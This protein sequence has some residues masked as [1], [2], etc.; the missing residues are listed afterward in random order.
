HEVRGGWQPTCTDCHDV[1]D[2]SSANL[3]L[4]ARMINTTG[5]VFQDNDL[6]SN[7]VSDFIHSNHASTS[8]DGVCEVCHTGTS[9]HRN[10]PAG[11][12]AHYADSLCTDCHPHSEG[13]KPGAGACTACH[14]QPPD[15]DVSPNLAGAHATHMTSTNGP[16]I[17]D[18]FECH[19]PLAAG[20]HLDGFTSFA[21]GVDA[22][23]NGD[24]ELSETDV[25]DACHSPGGAFDGVND[26]T[27]GAKP[28]WAEGVYSGSTLTPSK[29]LWCAGCHDDSPATI[30]GVDAPPVAGDN[31]TWGY[32]ATGHGRSGA[33]PCASCHDTSAPHFD[34]VANTYQAAADNYQEAFRLQSVNGGEPLVVP[35]TGNDWDDAY[36]DPSYWELCFT[37]HDRY[38]L[39]GGP[40]APAGPYY[41]D[42]F[43]TNFRSDASVLIPDGPPDTDIAQY[44][45]SGAADVNSH[46]THTVGPPHFYDSDRDGSVDSYGTCVACHNIHGSTSAAMVRDGKLLGMEPS[47]NFSRV[48]YD[49]HNP[50][51]GGC[52]DPIIMTSTNSVPLQE[53]HG[54]IMRTNS[55][56]GNNGVCNF[57]HGGGGSTGDPEYVINCYD[58]DN[59]DYYR[60]PVEA[61]NPC[62]ACHG[63]P[64]DG[65]EFPNTAGA[66]ATH[67]IGTN[68]PH[69]SD[70]FVC[71]A[72]LSDGVHNNAVASFASGID[73]NSN[74]DIE[75]DETDV[76]DACHSPDGPIDGVAE[77]IANW[78]AGT[79]VACAGC[80][81]TGTSTIQGVTAP[82]VAGDNVTW[83]Y[84]ATG[85]GRGG[86]VACTACHNA[87]ALHFDGEARTFSFES[88]QYGPSQSGVDYAAGYRLKDVDGEVP[89]M[90]PANYNITFDYNAAT[91]R[92]N[93]FR[94]CFSCHDITKVFDDTPGDGIDSNF[95]AS[96][97]NPPR[98]YSYA[99][100]S[101]A[102]VNEHVA[103]V[104]NYVG[105]FADSDWDEATDGP[106]GTEGRDSLTA[107]SSCHNVHGAAGNCGST[108]ETMI[109]DGSLV[110]RPGGYGFSH[111]VEDVGAGGY[112]TVT[113]VEAT[114]SN[115]VGAIFR[116]NT[117]NMCGGSMCHGNPDP[118]DDCSYDASGSSWGT[119]LEYF[120]PWEDHS[121]CTAC[122]ADAVDNGDNVPP[123]GRRA[124]V[125]EFPTGDAHAHYGAQFGDD[126]CGICHSLGTHTDG[127]VELID[128]DDASVYRF[129]TPA[130]LTADPDVSDFCS[131][132]HD[133]DGAQR[134][135]S[136]LD[137][138]GN[139]NAPPDA[140]SKFQG[141]LQWI[142]EY[143]DT[144]FGTWGTLRAVNSH[145]DISDS[146]QAFSGAKIE[147][148]DC[149]GAH[150]SA[151]SQPLIDPYAPLTPWAGDDDTFCLQCHNGGTGPQSPDLPAGVVGP[152][153]DTEELRS[154][155]RSIS[156]VCTNG[157]G[158]C[159]ALRGIESCEYTGAPW[160]VAYDWTHS[161]HGLTSKRGWTGYSG[162]P[163]A[164]VSCTVCHDPHGSYTPTNT[165]G[166]PYLI[167]D[168]VDGT[169]FVDDGTRVGGFNGP[170]FNSNGT[171][172]EVIVPADGVDVGWGESQG[173]CV[174]CHADWMAGMWAHDMCTACQGCHAHGSSW[175]EY[176]WADD[177]DHEPCPATKKAHGA[178]PAD[179][180][181]Q[182]LLPLDPSELTE[183]DIAALR[184]AIRTGMRQVQDGG[185]A[186]D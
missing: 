117:N 109:R 90:I 62:T 116:Y 75:L 65:T 183:E 79:P 85:H 14:G 42:E 9:Y 144:C 184:N 169:A 95:K 7:G 173:L 61:P 135:A 175:G 30:Q 80:H 18:C 180:T 164:T 171:V 132:C 105:P 166:N 89:L 21:S 123:G 66:H 68:G 104:M 129:Q 37:C 168:Q 122:H 125:P 82:P 58:P 141:T 77:G 63:Q 20:V 59:V 133:A 83:G 151:A 38:A 92:D 115:S 160:H 40:T 130:D 78:A 12:H 131:G 46:Y 6:G 27:I 8:Y 101:G 112:P 176:D 16:Q 22:N 156:D 97:P 24:I 179:G 177:D 121:S 155:G 43:S 5:M 1:H 25:C 111:V 69:V 159:F 70:C 15:G 98:N 157:S 94:L 106:G 35:R 52:S 36:D 128:P 29:S 162:A 87:N 32:Y 145:H 170:P 3:A 39:F 19:A 102:D 31:A 153:L 186:H 182:G 81:D 110:N 163:E 34:G 107:C 49:R 181:R 149:H 26:P 2:P 28:N 103:H 136:P 120:R 167:R 127:Y 174:V 57:C 56:P 51:Q 148:L 54:G 152:V 86:M 55:S 10:S 17:G 73:A 113:S 91:M 140:A 172:R 11:D 150:T 158:D 13:F 33:V 67:M 48:R 138:F 50:S 108:N 47:I 64:P 139:G 53:S 76:C 137:P 93:A 88:G 161:V 142:E 118:P 124:I 4:V 154:R 44:S 99:W 71:H 119:Y 84:Y 45:V 96:L 126:A 134:L 23:S 147:C 72:D 165:A 74:G 143:S 41:A 146:D 185:V 60:V 100:G 178:G 114:K